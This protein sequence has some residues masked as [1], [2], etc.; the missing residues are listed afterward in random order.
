MLSPNPNRERMPEEYV[1]MAYQSIS[2]VRKIPL[3]MK[4]YL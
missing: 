3:Q 4:P 2:Q 1:F